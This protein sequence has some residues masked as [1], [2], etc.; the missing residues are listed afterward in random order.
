MWIG[1]KQPAL[2][3]TWHGRVVGQVLAMQ[4]SKGWV[5]SLGGRL[6]VS[7]HTELRNSNCSVANPLLSASVERFTSA[8]DS[9][10][11]P[12]HIWPQAPAVHWVLTQL[13][14]VLP[15]MMGGLDGDGLAP[16]N[17]CLH[18]PCGLYT[19]GIICPEC[20][21]QPTA[22]FVEYACVCV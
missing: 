10:K 3:M 6:R 20:K 8:T 15:V 1:R 2:G 9:T 18:L 11:S 21:V 22:P 14:V 16:A 19:W 4:L 17:S 12:A 13:W 5:M 7:W